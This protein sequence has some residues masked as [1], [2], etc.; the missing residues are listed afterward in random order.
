MS[1]RHEN[2]AR[3][4]TANIAQAAPARLIVKRLTF[5]KLIWHPV[6]FACEKPK[7]H[8]QI[9]STNNTTTAANKA[10]AIHG[11][12]IKDRSPVVLV[13]LDHQFVLLVNLS[14][15]SSLLCKPKPKLT[16][17][18]LTWREGCPNIRVM[19]KELKIHHWLTAAMARLTPRSR[20][21]SPSCRSFCVR[22]DSDILFTSL[23]ALSRTEWRG[24]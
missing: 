16:F 21:I 1:S 20:P 9:A 19:S 3:R 17:D 15:V 24:P 18:K 23:L 2:K 7:D 6:R 8:C 14:K 12:A 22:L 5:D 11:D 4:I 10:N 13:A